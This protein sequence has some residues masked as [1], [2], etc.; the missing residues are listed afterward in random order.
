[1]AWLLSLRR[2]VGP[3]VPEPVPNHEGSFVTVAE[4]SG[5]GEPRICVLFRWVAGR[6]RNI[7]LTP[8]NLAAVGGLMARL[9]DQAAGFSP[10]HEF[11]RWRLCDVAPDE[12]AH[13]IDTVLDEC[14]PDDA[15]LVATVLDRVRHAVLAL[16]E[17]P[18][19]FG[20][21]HGDLH[22]HNY[23]FH[24]GQV[25]AIDFDDCGWGHFLYDIAVTL[26]EVSLRP[27]ARALRDGF[28]EGY[29]R[30]RPLP[31][32]LDEHLP[33][34][35]ALRELRLTMWVLEQRDDPGFKYWETEVRDGLLYLRDLLRR[36]DRG[37]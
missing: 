33:A 3:C 19:T 1:M 7:G 24:Q 23:L 25:S 9:H 4:V 26:S 31:A 28:L 5:H 14:G 12:S 30:V 11:R 8:S 15:A 18:D 35:L 36:I 16:D 34:F 17:A 10:L 2:D 29:G 22:Q 20:M 37:A 27:D 21:I 32:G 6:F 13:A